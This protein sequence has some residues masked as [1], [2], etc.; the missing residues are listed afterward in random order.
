MEE[1]VNIKGTRKGLIIKFD[2]NANFEDIKDYLQKKME[3]A[4]GFFKGAKF[5]LH[6][7][8]N[9][10]QE[11]ISELEMIC[12]NYGLIPTEEP[13]EMPTMPNPSEANVDNQKKKSPPDEQQTLLVKRT[14]RSGQSIRYH[15]HV[16]V[17]GDV[18]AGAEIT[19]G[20]SIIVL[21]RCSGVVHAGATGNGK[22]KV[23]ANRLC[24]TQLRIDTAIVRSPEEEPQY[25][26]IAKI[27]GGMIL[28]EKYLSSHR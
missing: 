27:S 14:L 2:S 9:F 10:L 7:E 25:P 5:T 16:V 4:K 28:V 8:Q 13:I 23:I 26:E 20:G 11:Q 24:P 12:T 1:P 21:G 15:G 6:H 3:S 17:L 22:A 18:N 19:A